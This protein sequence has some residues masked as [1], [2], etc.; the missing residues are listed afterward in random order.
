MIDEWV[1]KTVLAVKKYR[2]QHASGNT[3]YTASEQHGCC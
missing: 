3:D 2:E 1:L